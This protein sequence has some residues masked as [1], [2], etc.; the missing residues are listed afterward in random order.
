MMYAPYYF[1]NIRKI[2]IPKHIWPQEFLRKDSRPVL[3]NAER[4]VFV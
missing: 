1:S 2:P 4:S 3:Q